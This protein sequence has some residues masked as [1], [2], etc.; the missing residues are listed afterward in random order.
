MTGDTT[1]LRALADAQGGVVLTAQ[2][3]A[4]GW[5]RGRLG[6]FLASDGWARIRGGAWLA[7]G[8]EAGPEELLWAHQLLRPEFVV[9][10]WSAA[11]LHGV[12]GGPPARPEFV[13]A[14]R[15]AVK[16]VTLAPAAAGA[17]RGDGRRGPA[18]D[19]R[20][21][22]HGGPAAG[23]APG[24]GAAGGRLGPRLAARR[25]TGRAGRAKTPADHARRD[26]PCPDERPGAARCPGRRLVAGAGRPQGGLPRLRMHDAGLHPETQAV[27]VVPATGRRVYPDFLF[28]RQGLVVETEGYAWHGSRAQH[29]RDVIRFNALAACPEARRILRFTTADVR[30]RPALM[31]RD[32]RA[33][34]A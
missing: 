26:R 25:G 10:H 16:G 23:R 32:I 31:I 18:G 6:L 28:R 13:C 30:D 12:E 34:L 15:A 2:A 19:H 20:R 22:D 33:A 7:P 8:R 5:T 17:R 14:A 29:Q 3:L 24:R 1:S 9:S 4:G 21:A 11:A 27:L